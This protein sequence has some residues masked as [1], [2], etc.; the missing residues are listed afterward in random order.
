M[1]YAHWE[2]FCVNAFKEVQKYLKGLKLKPLETNINLVVRCFD[3]KFNYLKSK[4]S[5]DQRKEFTESFHELYFSNYLTFDTKVDTKSNLRFEVLKD[6]CTQFDFKF[7]NF[8]SIESELE[9]LVNIRNSIAHGENGYILVRKNIFSFL[10]TV[11]DAFDI[12][13]LEINDYLINEKFR[14]KGLSISLG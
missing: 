8:S 10:Q 3:Q 6:L 4:Q 1:I 5:F 14:A 13:V 9:K 7:D 11:E 12:L 2:G